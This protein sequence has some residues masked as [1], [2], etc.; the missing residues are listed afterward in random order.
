M[1]LGVGC[2]S[3]DG[4]VKSEQSDDVVAVVD[5]HTLLGADI[6]RDMP[7]GLTGVDSV[8]FARMYVDNWVL[9]RLKMERAEQVLSSYEKDIERLVEGYRQSLI[10]RQLD[11]YYIDHALD[12][13]ITDKQLSAYYRAHSASFKLDH[14]KVRAV[15]VKTPRTFRNVTTL[16][17]ALK[18]VAR[19]GSTEEVAALVEKHN[20][21][22]SDLTAEWVS[23][24]DFLSHLPTERSQSYAGLLSKDGVQT[25]TSDN[26]T[27]YFIITDVVRKGE[28]APIECV[29][30]DI[31]RRLYAERR[32]E[33]V[34]RYEC[35]L[36]R[37]AVEAGR[38][39][40]A[41]S[42]LLKSM[43]YTAE[44]DDIAQEA[45]VRDAEDIVEDDVP[46]VETQDV[47]LTEEK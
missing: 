26:A 9:N 28:V 25:M 30:E 29:E 36:R 6:R 17:T 13:E 23:Y 31:R 38:V 2:Y 33:I 11:Q 3:N 42:V 18:G 24:S 27:F 4:G 22:L 32:E 5:G 1:T 10:M 35:E 15:V 16:T 44:S 14:D 21:Q 47:D 12:I 45:H 7:H 46:V 39:T 19:S 41:D 37:E 8:T 43:S 20:L 40:L 34:A